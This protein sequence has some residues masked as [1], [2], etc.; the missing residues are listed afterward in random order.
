MQPLSVANSWLLSPRGQA[1]ETLMGDMWSHGHVWPVSPPAHTLLWPWDL[2]FLF[3]ESSLSGKKPHPE[4]PTV[5][6]SGSRPNTHTQ[7]HTHTHT[8]MQLGTSVQEARR[9]LTSLCFDSLGQVSHAHSVW[10]AKQ[11]TNENNVPSPTSRSRSSWLFY[12]LQ[13]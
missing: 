8:Y 11:A 13:F 2:L 7:R 12:F 6:P 9:H 4:R 3:A 10:A 1:T 5:T